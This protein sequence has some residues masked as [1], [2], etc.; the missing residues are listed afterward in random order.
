M[1]SIYASKIFQVA[2]YPNDDS[3]LVIAI[4]TDPAKFGRIYCPIRRATPYRYHLNTATLL[5]LQTTHE[6]GHVSVLSPRF[7]PD[8]ST[9]LWLECQSGG[10]HFKSTRL[11]ATV[12]GFFLFLLL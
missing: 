1:S 12:S 6:A 3:L 7:T 9:L 5:Q 11:V 10:P 2:W 4:A 8:G